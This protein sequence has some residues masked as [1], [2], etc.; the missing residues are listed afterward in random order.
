MSADLSVSSELK[1]L[2]DELAVSQR[3]RTSPNLDGSVASDAKAAT[4]AVQSEEAVEDEEVRSEFRELAD[5]LT[6]IFDEAE[7]NLSAHPVAS[8]RFQANSLHSL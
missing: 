2:R 5:E 3:A 6:K 4:A 1:S 7:R 8:L